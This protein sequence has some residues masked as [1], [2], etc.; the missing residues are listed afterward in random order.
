MA[1]WRALTSYRLGCK[2]VVIDINPY[3]VEIGLS[4]FDLFRL[5]DHVSY[6]LAT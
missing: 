2:A 4:C 5:K 1:S 6:M 3:L